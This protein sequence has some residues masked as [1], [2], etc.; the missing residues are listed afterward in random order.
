MKKQNLI[1]VTALIVGVLAAILFYS[2][3][4]YEEPQSYPEPRWVNEI[5]DKINPEQCGAS[6]CE[7]CDTEKCTERPDAC[8][9]TSA[10]YACGPACDASISF[11]TSF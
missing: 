11:C 4:T 7:A 5:K 9:V 2:F 6:N 10:R 3:Q 1:I 8:E